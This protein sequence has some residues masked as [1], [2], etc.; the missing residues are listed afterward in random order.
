M[1]LSNF[2]CLR[3]R[4][5]FYDHP[6]YNT[7]DEVQSLIF[8]S[9]HSED[10]ASA[11]VQRKRVP[12]HVAEGSVERS[13]HPGVGTQRGSDGCTCRCSP[14]VAHRACLQVNLPNKLVLFLL[15]CTNES[16]S[17]VQLLFNQKYNM[18]FLCYFLQ[19]ITFLFQFQS[20]YC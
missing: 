8:F 3:L 4:V 7:V 20:N 9:A 12:L 16:C 1:F 6:N 15:F 18:F 19:K 17:F 2:L 13:R 10:G 11:Y 5:K 14:Q